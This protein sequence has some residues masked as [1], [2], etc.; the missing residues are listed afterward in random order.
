[1]RELA[2]AFVLVA[3]GPPPRGDHMK[4][5]APQ[6][7]DAAPP[8]ATPLSA[9][10]SLVCPDDERADVRGLTPLV[11]EQ[12]TAMKMP[13]T[14]QE[15]TLLDWKPPHGRVSDQPT[16]PTGFAQLLVR[17]GDGSGLRVNAYL[18]RACT[19]LGTRIYVEGGRDFVFLYVVPPGR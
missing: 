11:L 1:M 6:A 19:V 12:G 3:C 17:D 7:P 2:L 8:D 16:G 5:P 13:G 4:P 14:T 9:Y 10:P 15:V 18:F